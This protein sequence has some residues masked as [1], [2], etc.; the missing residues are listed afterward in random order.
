VEHGA[1]HRHAEVRLVHGRH[2][3]QQ[4]GHLAKFTPSMTKSKFDFSPA[5]QFNTRR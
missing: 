1:A 5:T 4:H 3:R 2:V